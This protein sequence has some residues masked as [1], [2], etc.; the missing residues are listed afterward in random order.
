MFK[1][2]FALIF[3]LL[4]QLSAHSLTGARTL[5]MGNAFV[6]VK[7]IS[8]NPAALNLLQTSEGRYLTALNKK[9]LNSY[10]KDFSCCV[11]GEKETAFG[12][13]YCYSAGSEINSNIYSLAVSQKINNKLSIGGTLKVYGDSLQN[14]RSLA[15][16]VDLGFFLEASPKI[17]WGFLFQDINQP[18]AS[19]LAGEA[20]HK[21]NVRGGYAYRPDEKTIFAVD[22]DIYDPL[23]NMSFPKFSI[24]L[25]TRFRENLTLRMG[26]D[27]F[28]VTPF[29]NLPSSYSLGMGTKL[30][31]RLAA[32]YAVFYTPDTNIPA[33]LF[34]HYVG[35]GVAL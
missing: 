25:E 9:N 12:I 5:G 19:F 27:Q 30:F 3:V 6:A 10:E 11:L 14:E 29:K 17:S 18:A 20:A 15:A 4:A 23:G 24:G 34:Y 13:S 2:K 26:W 22:L 32:D 7:E 21:L 8:E 35:F 16:G 33:D 28:P 31:G 1:I